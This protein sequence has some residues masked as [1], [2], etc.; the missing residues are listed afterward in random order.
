MS[1]GHAD[2]FLNTPA[3]AHGAPSGYSVRT[4]R[5]TAATAGTPGVDYPHKDGAPEDKR[6]RFP[7]WP[8]VM[9]PASRVTQ[10]DD[11]LRGDGSVG[12]ALNTHLDR[13][14]TTTVDSCNSSPVPAI[15]VHAEEHDD[16]HLH[17]NPASAVAS[18]RF[19]RNAQLMA[20]LMGAHVVRRRQPKDWEFVLR[21]RRSQTVML[22]EKLQTYQAELA[23]L[24]DRLQRKQRQWLEADAA[25]LENLRTC[26]DRGRLLQVAREFRGL[27]TRPNACKTAFRLSC[28]P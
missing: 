1:R 3:F 16:S 10:A 12:F 28:F 20:E 26:G 27:P 17:R 4:R 25:F 14:C 24:E 13:Q 7:C 6:G 18:R 5:A 22:E 11:W 21:D 8:I 15:V 19:R 23:E 2:R 9:P